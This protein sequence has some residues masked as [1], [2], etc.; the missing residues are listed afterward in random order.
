MTS[1]KI[2]IICDGDRCGNKPGGWCRYLNV[3]A[4]NEHEL[5]VLCSLFRSRLAML[6]N[7]PMRCKMCRDGEIKIR[8]AEV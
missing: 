1:I 5:S 3:I 6:D 2:D 4:G 7:R 8:L